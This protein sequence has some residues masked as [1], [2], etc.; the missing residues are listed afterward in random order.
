MQMMKKTLLLLLLGSFP[1]I[2]WGNVAG[3]DLWLLQAGDG[4]GGAAMNVPNPLTLVR[5]QSDGATA[6]ILNTY[7]APSTDA[8]TRVTA[9]PSYVTDGQLSRSQDNRYLVFP[10]YDAA[11]GQAG[12]IAGAVA[13][14][15]PRVVARFDTHTGT[16][17]TST[18]LTDA[19]NSS[20]Y[21]GATTL[22]GSQFWLTGNG[23]GTANSGVRYTT[24]GASSSVNV[25]TVNYTTAHP[26]I[27]NNQVYF[28]RTTGTAGSDANNAGVLSTGGL[29]TLAG[30]S[31]HPDTLRLSSGDWLSGEGYAGFQ[32]S[33][34]G[35]A[36]FVAS[37]GL[38]NTATRAGVQVYRYDQIASLWNLTTVINA[39]NVRQLD[40]WQDG[41]VVQV[42]Y[43]SRATSDP[44][45]GE[46]FASALWSTSY[47]LTTNTFSTPV[48]L[49][50]A[51]E[52]TV[53]WGVVIVP[54]PATVA[55]CMALGAGLLV[56]LRRRRR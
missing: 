53:Y 46:A 20:N 43:T 14:S 41:D 52:G 30:E 55:L 31:G 56:F 49:L 17:D 24:L 2:G 28:S 44:L 42:F 47:N 50:T 51:P 35:S 27:F 38:N 36:L 10:G 16:F 13:S 37:L 7:A 45:G 18:R 3:F 39:D 4:V 25:L 22:D 48:A 15:V 40:V 12:S 1:M 21:R 19:F 26:V 8:A 6:S 34:D 54:E 5:V 33:S 23:S 29:Q 9:V 32:L 11:V